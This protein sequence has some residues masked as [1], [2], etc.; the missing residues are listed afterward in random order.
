MTL[1]LYFWCNEPSHFCSLQNRLRIHK[2]KIK[3][4][5]FLSYHYDKL[6][7]HGECPISQTCR[8]GAM[9]PKHPIFDNSC[10]KVNLTLEWKVPCLL[11]LPHIIRP[12]DGILWRNIWV[13]LNLY[14]WCNS[15]FRIFVFCQNGLITLQVKILLIFCLCHIKYHDKLHLHGECQIS[16]TYMGATSPK[17]LFSIIH[18]YKVDLTITIG[19]W[20]FSTLHEDAVCHDQWCD[21]EKYQHY[22]PWKS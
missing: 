10:I 18:V 3:L 22:F 13:T 7:L 6:H 1:N 20:N 17:H 14:F 8:M 21:K 15:P 9:S 12:C 2:A 16:G 5:F 11:F 4:I 19:T